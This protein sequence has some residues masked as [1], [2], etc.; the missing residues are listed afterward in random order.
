MTGMRVNF[1]ITTRAMKDL[2]ALTAKDRNAIILK[3]QT[4]AHTGAGDVKK[5]KGRPEYRLRHG[6]WRAMFEID[7]GVVVLRVLH[8]SLA[9]D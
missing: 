1:H 3:L 9:Y 4:F 6:V 8:R 7:D 5:L 2:N